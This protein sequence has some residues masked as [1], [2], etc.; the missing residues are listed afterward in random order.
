MNGAEQALGQRIRELRRRHFGAQG[1]ERFAARLGV[2]ADEYARY[3]R[4][5]VPPGD[6]L[7]RIC[8]VTGEDLQWLLTGV[9]A[10]GTVVI[11]GTRGRHQDLLARLARLLDEHP[12]LAAPVE[13]F[14]SLLAGTPPGRAANV[15]ALPV[16]SVEYLIPVFEAEELP[17]ALAT[18]PEDAPGPFDLAPYRGDAEAI[19]RIS[20]TLTEPAM[21]YAPEAFRKAELLTLRAPEG[22]PRRCLHSAEIACCFPNAF[23][24]RLADESM[25][26]MFAADDA[27][28]VAVGVG[29]KVGQPALCRVADEAGVR[30]RIWLGDDEGLV[31]LGRIADGECEQVPRDK[32]L[33]SLEV[34]YRLA[35]AA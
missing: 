12:E 13:A 26:P 14:V 27:V 20:V 6:V 17:L 32:L 5:A 19:E 34:L 30:C 35:R 16:Q 23:G 4:G 29:P 2:S 31:R 3:E 9:A 24:V 33:W 8:E 15:P 25:A 1:K 28:L 11:S 21:S 22:R 18:T 10:R 7:V